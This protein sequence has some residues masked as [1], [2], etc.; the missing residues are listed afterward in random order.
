M[1]FFSTRLNLN[2]KGLFR[3]ILFCH[4]QQVKRVFLKFLL[5]I[6]P[7]KFHSPLFYV[8]KRV[9]TFPLESVSGEFSESHESFPRSWAFAHVLCILWN[10][11][12]QKAV[13][14]STLQEFY[15][16]LAEV[17]FVYENFIWLPL[18]DKVGLAKVSRVIKNNISGEKKTNISLW[19]ISAL[20]IVWI[21]NLG[22]YLR[23]YILRS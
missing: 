13:P 17:D 9:E 20:P 15:H 14:K 23:K 2:H 21:L 1:N 22:I 8:L 18:S 16:Y 5:L 4:K 19:R 6:A 12:L 10:R 7:H 3:F 11:T